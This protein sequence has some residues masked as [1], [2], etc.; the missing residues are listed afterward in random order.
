[1]KFNEMIN[2][3]IGKHS[4]IHKGAIYDN[5]Y[6]YVEH[7]TINI[8]THFMYNQLSIKS[9]HTDKINGAFNI[10]F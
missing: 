8:T 4:S 1:M 7:N 6:F 3:A 9:A 5:A 2:Q 10:V